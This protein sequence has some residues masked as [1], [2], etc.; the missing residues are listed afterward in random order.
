MFANS[1]TTRAYHTRSV[2]YVVCRRNVMIQIITAAAAVTYCCCMRCTSPAH[3]A[4]TFLWLRGAAGWFSPTCFIAHD[5]RRPCRFLRPAFI[6]YYSS[7]LQMGF[8]TRVRE[9]PS[10][11]I[12]TKQQR[13]AGV[14]GVRPALRWV[15]KAVYFQIR[16][17]RVPGV[18]GTSRGG[19]GV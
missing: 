4:A 8:A 9:Q 10:L 3:H 12:C 6:L 16:S 19:G 18:S 13:A 15:A 17:Q 1:T 5:T 2:S 11:P 14:G 7:S